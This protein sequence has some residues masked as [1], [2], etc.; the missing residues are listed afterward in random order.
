MYCL[1]WLFGFIVDGY[2]AA[3]VWRQP[4]LFD[5]AGYVQVALQRTVAHRD[6][7]GRHVEGSIPC[8]ASAGIDRF[9]S[10]SLDAKVTGNRTVV[11]EE[12]HVVELN[13]NGFREA[14]ED[15]HAH[16][17]RDAQR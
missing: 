5:I 14:G 8:D 16:R 4:E 11:I 13:L 1:G 17:S 2:I 15:H 3:G 7:G 6:H 12:R 9:G 10:R